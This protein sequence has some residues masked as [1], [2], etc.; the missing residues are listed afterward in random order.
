M[1]PRN[2]A[3]WFYD[4]NATPDFKQLVEKSLALFGVFTGVTLSFYIKDFLFGDNIPVG[5]LDF[6]IFARVLI[7]A[8]VIALLL[9]YIVGSAVHLNA[10]YVAKVTTK[11]ENGVLVETKEPKSRSMWW[12]FVDISFLVAFGLL[13]VVII[14]SSDLDKFLWNSSVFIGVGLVWSLIALI[15]RPGDRAV[16]ARWTVIDGCQLAVTASL[17]YYAV[18]W[19]DFDKTRVLTFIYGVCLFID[20]WVVSRPPP[21]LWVTRLPNA[22]A[23]RAALAARIAAL[24]T[25]LAALQAQLAALAP[26]PAAPP[27]PEVVAEPPAAATG[28]AI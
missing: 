26:P 25:E 15:G 3:Y 22:A 10:T 4:R 23:Q 6:S 28:A 9:R 2:G 18:N 17:Y 5:F 21:T 8:S 20:F 11:I 1:D 13:A 27:A 14:Y 7:S 16:A 12:L 19:S 24:Q